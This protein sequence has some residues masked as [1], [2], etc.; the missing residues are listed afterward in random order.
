MIVK[1]LPVGPPATDVKAMIDS[2]KLSSEQKELILKVVFPK[3]PKSRMVGAKRALEEKK[4]EE[5]KKLL[6]L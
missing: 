4:Y 5:I 1:R 2:L 6:S 3:R